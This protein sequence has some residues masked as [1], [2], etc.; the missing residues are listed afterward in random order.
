MASTLGRSWILQWQCFDVRDM[1]CDRQSHE[2]FN[3]INTI[4]IHKSHLPCFLSSRWGFSSSIDNVMASY[5]QIDALRQ[6]AQFEIRQH[7][8]PRLLAKIDSFKTSWFPNRAKLRAIQTLELLYSLVPFHS[9]TPT[10]QNDKHIKDRTRLPFLI[11]QAFQRF[12]GTGTPFKPSVKTDLATYSRCCLLVLSPCLF[13]LLSLS[14]HELQKKKAFGLQMKM[15]LLRL[16]F[17]EPLCCNYS[18]VSDIFPK[19]QKRSSC[20]PLTLNCVNH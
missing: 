13:Y 11:L 4:N 12:R 10:S 8:F 18:A 2:R 19:D 14:L 9:L 1:T 5:S 16:F 17:C 6:S 15:F 3:T 20:I 7:N